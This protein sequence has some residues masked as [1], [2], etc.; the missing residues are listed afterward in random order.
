MK[1]R[2]PWLIGTVVGFS[3]AL[4]LVGCDYWPPAL[5]SEI[6]QLRSETQTLTMEKIQLQAQVA[7]M[8][9]I[10]QELQEQIDELSRVNQGKT[11]MIT[12]LQHQLDTARA[13]ALKAMTPR[14][15]PHKTQVKPAMKGRPASKSAPKTPANKSQTPKAMGFD[16]RPRSL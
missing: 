2:S 10:K 1:C 7:D 6:E 15:A 16:N 13:R 12:S 14:T 5:Q 3:F 9:K 11:A 4:G 8:S